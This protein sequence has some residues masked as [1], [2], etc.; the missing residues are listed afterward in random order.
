MAVHHC[1]PVSSTI[2][3]SWTTNRRPIRRP[4]NTRNRQNGGNDPAKTFSR[5]EPRRNRK[6][7]HLIIMNEAGDTND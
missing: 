4:I 3:N 2:N 1:V 6:L 5:D 7:V